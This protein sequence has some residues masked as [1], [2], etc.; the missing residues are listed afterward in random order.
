MKHEGSGFPLEREFGAKTMVR[1]LADESNSIVAVL[2]V[3]ELPADAEHVVKRSVP[4]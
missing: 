2:D 1:S 4:A 3:L